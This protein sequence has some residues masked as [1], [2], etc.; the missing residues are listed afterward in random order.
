MARRTIRT[1]DGQVFSDSCSRFESRKGYVLYRKGSFHEVH[2]SKRAI[3]SDDTSGLPASWVMV[4]AVFSVMTLIIVSLLIS[5]K[6]GTGDGLGSVVLES[7]NRPSVVV[8]PY[9]IPSPV[10]IA[11]KKSGNY[12]LASCAEYSRV[13]AEHKILFNSEENAIKAGYKWYPKC[14]MPDQSRP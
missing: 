12:Y 14:S 5:R 3:I 1:M 8:T 7:P 9:P 10:V 11:S 4:I 2:I 6:M 13:K